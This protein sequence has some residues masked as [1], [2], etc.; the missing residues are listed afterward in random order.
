MHHKG[1]ILV[2]GATGYIGGRL[3][4]RLLEAGYAPKGLAGHL[5]WNLL[6]PFHWII[7]SGLC[8]KISQKAE[9]LK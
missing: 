1:T 2:T 8:K 7:F 3:V 5:Y 6:Y 9:N 4:P